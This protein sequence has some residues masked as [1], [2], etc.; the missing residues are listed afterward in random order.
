MAYHDRASQDPDEQ[1]YDIAHCSLP[2]E[3]MGAIITGVPPRPQALPPSGEG[4]SAA[5]RTVVIRGTQPWRHDYCTVTVTEAVPLL[6]AGSN[7][8]AEMVCE[9]PDWIVVVLLCCFLPLPLKLGELELVVD[10]LQV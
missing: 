4:Y 2:V 6:P 10:K 9:V 5:F 1:Q 7:A 8:V 3:C